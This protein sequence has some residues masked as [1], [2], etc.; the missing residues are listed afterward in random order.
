MLKSIRDFE[1]KGKRVLLRTDFNI[2]LDEKG[3]IEDDFRIKQTIP[4]IQYLIKKGA[5]IILISHLGRPKGKSKKYS[6]KPVSSRIEELL[7]KKIRFT[8]K[9]EVGDINEGEIVLMENLRFHP[10]EMENDQGFAQRLSKLGEIYIN[11]AFSVCHR[12]HA[13]IVGIPKIL[14]SGIGLLLE[15]EINALSKVIENPK[16]PLIAVIGGIKLST[17]IGIIKNFLK[18]ADHLL[19]GGKIFEPFL[20]AKGIL[21]GKTFLSEEMEN[22]LEKINL[23]DPKIHL[24]V[25]GVISLSGLEEDYLHKSAIGKVRKDEGIFDI[26]PETIK[27]FSLLIESAGTIILSGPMGYFEREPFD[28]GSKSIVQA[29]IKNDSAFKVAGGGETNMFLA[30]YGFRE[31]FNHISTGGGAMLAF[32]AGNKLPGIEALK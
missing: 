10:E 4:T 1:I 13:S 29:I 6:L 5:K 22:E 15:N 31:K 26:G 19:L 24:P 17:K 14:P 32:L 21:V 3:E 11:D 12:N 25:D 9:E 8:D 7:N 16:R 18:T 27:L 2:P 28:I 23:T 20:I 30:K